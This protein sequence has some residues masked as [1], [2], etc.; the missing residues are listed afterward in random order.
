[1][2]GEIYYLLH[3]NKMTNNSKEKCAKNMKKQVTEYETEMIN[4]PFYLSSA[5]LIIIKTQN[6]ITM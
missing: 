2:N 1:M 3:I 4:K 5:S 6:K